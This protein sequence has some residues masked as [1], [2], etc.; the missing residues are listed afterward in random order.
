MLQISTWLRVLIGTI[1]LIGLLIALPNAIPENVRA[2]FPKWLPA[3]TVSLG[4][5]LQGGSYLLEEVEL[6]QVQKER[7]E[8]LM[9]DIRSGLRKARIGYT[10][11][12]SH[13]D[14]VSVQVLDP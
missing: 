9:G 14:S 5:D 2:K 1:L 4:L 7:L 12:E 3:N 11:L 8:S 6:D 10:N 13:G